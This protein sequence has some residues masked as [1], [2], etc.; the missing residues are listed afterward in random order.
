MINQLDTENLQPS[1]IPHI[2]SISSQVL[3]YF[4][5]SD[6]A[7]KNEWD[8]IQREW[9]A[10]AD[11][12]KVNQKSCIT[13]LIFAGAAISRS[14]I[15]LRN[16][17][18]KTILDAR[19]NYLAS[20]APPI[21]PGDTT[22]SGTVG[23]ARLSR[24]VKS[25]HA[26]I[27]RKAVDL[28]N[29]LLSKNK[30][31]L[32]EKIT[33]LLSDASKSLRIG[34]SLKSLSLPALKTATNEHLYKDKRYESAGDPRQGTS[35]LD[36]DKVKVT[37]PKNFKFSSD[38]F[39]CIRQNEGGGDETFWVTFLT[40]IDNLQ[41]VYELIDR[42]V[43][44]NTILELN[45]GSHVKFVTQRKK[46]P[47]VSCN[48]NDINKHWNNPIDFGALRL[49]KG[50]FPWAF[51]GKCIEDDNSE[52]NA[53]SEI[54]DEI[55]AAAGMISQGASIVVAVS[56][57]T[58][59]AAG[60]AVVSAAAGV[61]SLC[62]DIG[63]AVV[64]IVNYFDENDLI[65]DVYV[66]GDGDHIGAPEIH[67]H[68]QEYDTSGALSG[69][70]YKLNCIQ[71]FSGSEQVRRNWSCTTEIKYGKRDQHSG[72][73]GMGNSGETNYTIKFSTPMTI[74]LGSGVNLESSR[75]YSHAEWI[76]GPKLQSDGITTKGKV[77]WGVS[78]N[79]TVTYK[80]YVNGIRIIHLL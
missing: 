79:H 28:H 41:E 78:W 12:G 71:T 61:V 24:A 27:I 72:I 60:A 77:H 3:A 38:Y 21:I 4:A 6:I 75:N 25:P 63:A 14:D 7:L 47:I 65:G 76:S 17:L 40:Y 48:S 57:P 9:L 69:G 45:I 52:Y 59:V 8:S 30:P 33:D 10:V 18:D 67:N 22:G 64:D 73:L 66:N 32:K 56:G 50:F 42:A 31:I 23:P 54:F 80:P 70:Y 36:D 20:Q 46:T 53:V 37:V 15:V 34:Y 39:R 29:L 74:L 1:D 26:D 58:V 35:V 19:A 49:H 11:Y 16:D 44:T 68:S 13:A 51:S 55:G 2:N 62:A 43:K 5:P